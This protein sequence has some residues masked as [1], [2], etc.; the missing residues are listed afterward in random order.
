MARD[1]RTNAR[2]YNDR[3]KY[4]KRIKGTQDIEPKEAGVFY[5]KDVV[6]LKAVPI[7]INGKA[8]G[9]QFT[10]TIVTQDIIKDLETDDVVEYG[11]DRYRIASIVANDTNEN[12]QFSKR[13]RFETTIEL[14]R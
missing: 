7:I 6:P 5:S 8:K 1:V 11:G 9:R 13:P 12:K 14:V 2:E 3:N 10:V 4:Y